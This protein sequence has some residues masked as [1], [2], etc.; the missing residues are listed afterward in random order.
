METKAEKSFFAELE[1]RNGTSGWA[2]N[3]V[4]TYEIIKKK[5]AVER[6]VFTN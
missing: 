5:H 4:G 2:G 1:G 3:N 6:Y